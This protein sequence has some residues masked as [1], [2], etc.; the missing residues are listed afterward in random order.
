MSVSV[1]EQ[2]FDLSRAY[3][4]RLAAERRQK[5]V[6]LVAHESLRDLPELSSFL[7]KLLCPALHGAPRPENFGQGG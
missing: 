4:C 2:T 3:A 6:A 1:D 7:Q 5:A